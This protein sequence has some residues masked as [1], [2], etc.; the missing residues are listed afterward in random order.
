MK[1]LK[2]K[3]MNQEYSVRKVGREVKRRWRDV[4]GIF[5]FR[6]G[7]IIGVGIKYM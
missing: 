4:K 7:R 2:Q 5:F 1:H 3:V 6:K